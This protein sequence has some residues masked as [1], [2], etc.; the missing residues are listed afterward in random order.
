LASTDKHIALRK[1][2]LLSQSPISYDPYKQP[3]SNQGQEDYV[4]GHRFHNYSP[5][6]DLLRKLDEN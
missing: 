5:H 2:Q 1:A 6:H 3:N 4:N